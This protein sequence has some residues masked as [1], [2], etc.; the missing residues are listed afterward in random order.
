MKL[1][2]GLPFQ[3]GAPQARTDRRKKA[4]AHLADTHV[5]IPTVL[6][7]LSC[8]VVSTERRTR[9]LKDTK[10][11]N[12]LIEDPG[13][14]EHVTKMRQQLDRQCTLFIFLRRLMLR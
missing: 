11:R 12:S 6:I 14:V 5:A 9:V 10:P 2:I 1:F 4:L 8:E 3:H 7:F 13:R